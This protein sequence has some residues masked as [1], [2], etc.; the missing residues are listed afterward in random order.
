MPCRRS[1]APQP[2]TRCRAPE[3]D[4]RTRRANRAGQTHQLPIVPA[5]CVGRCWRGAPTLAWLNVFME[6]HIRIKVYMHMAG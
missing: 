3:A 1:A 4:P 2:L 5:V 6:M